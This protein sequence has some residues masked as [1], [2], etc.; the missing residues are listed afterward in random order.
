MPHLTL[1][2]SKNLQEFPFQQFA[3]QAHEILSEYANVAKCKSKLEFVDD[4]YIAL[5]PS[6]KAIIYLQIAILSR[7]EDVLQNIGKRLFEL[8][9]NFAKPVLERLGLQAEVNL[10]LHVLSHYW[11]PYPFKNQ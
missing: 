5:D 8:L 4:F 3:H 2:L 11:Q 7:P 9:Q 1:T 6:N 10:E